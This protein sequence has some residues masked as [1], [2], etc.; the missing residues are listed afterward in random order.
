MVVEENTHTF[1]SR[2]FIVW[3]GVE[4]AA[5]ATGVVGMAFGQRQGDVGGIIDGN[6]EAKLLTPELV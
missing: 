4:V 6:R 5:E 3:Y 1:L 2:V